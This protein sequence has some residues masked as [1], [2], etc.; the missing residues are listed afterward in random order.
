MAAPIIRRRLF[1]VLL[2]PSLFSFKF[3]YLV[4]FKLYGGNPLSYFST[5][6]RHKVKMP[7][8]PCEHP[9]Y[10]LTQRF[11]PITGKSEWETQDENYDFHQEIARYYY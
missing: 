2:T 10:V 1:D 6:D 7:G 3:S 11:N 5:F 8:D 4:N 9:Q